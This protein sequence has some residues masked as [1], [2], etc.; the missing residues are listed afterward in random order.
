M[1]SYLNVEFPTL[2]VP[3]VRGYSFTSTH[4]RYEHETAVVKFIDWA[5]PYDSISANTPV[6]VTING[7][8]STR[9]FNGY[10]HHIEPDISPE[11][12]YVDLHL[13]GASYVFKQQS[14]KV[15]TDATA[16]QVIAD[17][18]QENDF[19]YVAIPTTRVY[20]QISQAG[21]SDW[22]LMVKL[23]KQNG[24]SLKADNTSIIFQPLTQDF[25]DLRQEA[26][27]YA[28]RGLETV[29]S[30]IYSFKP[31][32]GEAIPYA[33]ALKSTTA[34]SGVDRATSVDHAHTNQTQITTTRNKFVT[35]IFDSYHTHTV[36]PTY[37]IAAEE[38]N[39]ADE[40]NRY[41]YRGEVVIEGNPTVLPDSPIFLDGLG[42]IYSGYWIVLSSEQ[43]VKGNAEYYSTL[44]VGTDSLGLSSK[45]IDNK[46]INSPSQKIKRVIKPGVRQKNMPPKTSL[47]KTGHSAKESA[48]TPFSKV[49]NVS[50]TTS[51][52]APT[53]KWSGNGGN[54]KAPAI[55]ETKIPAAAMAKIRSAH[56]R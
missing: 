6:T 13:I 36:A 16:D 47:K 27:Y 51:K 56:G 8:G 15:W 55:I 34:I 38:A 24:Y 44:T 45:W 53:Y 40:R 10:I 31:M 39:A 42:N 5:V 11:K 49:K 30:G 14:Q 3:L 54:L 32:I 25:T 17:I 9:T 50:K 35:P 2:S 41:A 46:N 12:N 7:L 48:K 28:L 19:S 22:E 26:S 37:K 18:A 23:A 21:M 4:A 1:F 29:A 43:H 52:S 33:G 20:D